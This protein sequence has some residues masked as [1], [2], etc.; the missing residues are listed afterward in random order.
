M[1]FKSKYNIGDTIFRIR[2]G[3]KKSTIKAILIE[4]RKTNTNYKY[5]ID[6]YDYPVNKKELYETK[7]EAA[8]EWLRQQGLDCGLKQ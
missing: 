3:I 8:N 2:D 7:E 6:D 5:Y 1:T 4:H